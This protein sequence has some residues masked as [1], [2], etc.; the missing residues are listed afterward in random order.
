[1]VSLSPSPL[2]WGL[3]W[4][5]V[6]STNILRREKKPPHG[7]KS[8]RKWHLQLLPSKICSSA[9]V[10]QSHAAVAASLSISGRRLINSSFKGVNLA[11]RISQQ[12]AA[13]RRVASRAHFSQPN[14]R[15]GH[16]ACLSLSLL[17][18]VNLIRPCGAPA[19]NYTINDDG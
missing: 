5:R 19:K 6:T 16:Y 13:S 12:R 3:I 15:R 14:R 9:R 8:L 18:L 4:A 1:M 11:R 7:Q 2:F 17:W 10:T